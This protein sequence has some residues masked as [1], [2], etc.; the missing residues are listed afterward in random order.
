MS[1]AGSTYDEL[2]CDQQGPDLLIAFNNR[3]LIDSL[4]A[5]E[6]DELK[7]SLSSA[8]TSINIE[9]IC[10]EEENREEIFMLLPV[11]MKD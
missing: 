10:G 6:G 7:I 2:M 5:C 11:R 9:P 1:A 3:F 4:R 8:L